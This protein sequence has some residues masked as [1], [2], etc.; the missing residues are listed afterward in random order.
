M[1]LISHIMVYNNSLYHIDVNCSDMKFI[2]MHLETIE[3][4]SLLNTVD[5]PQVLSP[6]GQEL[7]YFRLV[8]VIQSKSQN[9]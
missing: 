5:L 3:N 9:Q 7:S 8:F 2:V 6:G 1:L 4:S